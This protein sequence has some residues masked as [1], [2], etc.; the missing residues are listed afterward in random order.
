ML[1]LPAGRLAR[2][3]CAM[4]WAG[5]P[6]LGVGARTGRRVLGMQVVEGDKAMNVA[7][8]G[9]GMCGVCV[10]VW[11]RVSLLRIWESAAI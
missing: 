4:V 6:V 9:V 8:V 1:A 2:G 3:A 11:V 5:A 7:L 10:L